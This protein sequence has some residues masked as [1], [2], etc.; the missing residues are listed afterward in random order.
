M[1]DV[2]P[3]PRPGLTLTQKILI[4]LAVGTI[5]GAWVSW[6]YPA[7]NAAVA[8][9]R[10]TWLK[11]MSTGAQIFLRMIKMIIGPL[12]FSTLVV[13]VAGG[14]HAKAVGRMGLRAII[15]FEVVTTVALFLGLAAVNLVKPGAGIN[16]PP[17]TESIAAKPQTW[18]QILVHLVPESFMRAMAENDVLQVVVFSLVFALALGQLGERGKTFLHWCETLAEIMFKFT[19]LVMKFAPFGVGAAIG[20]TI[21]RSGVGVL[22]NLIWLI[23]TVYVATAIFIVFVLLPI[24]WGFKVPIRK[25]WKVVKEPALIAFSTTSS[26]AALPRALEN[27]ERLGCPRRIVSFVLPLGYTFNLDGTTLFLSLASIFVAQA[28]GMDLTLGQQ[29]TMMLTLMLT[30]KGVAGVPRAATV[31]LAA[32]AAQFNLPMEGVM[33][34][35]GV[36][37]LMDMV[38]TMTNVIGNCLATVVIAKWEGDFTEASDEELNQADAMGEL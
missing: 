35:F 21:G 29:L 3:A 33:L 14:G 37:A 12:L 5:V 22:V 38:R 31:I 26:E 16:L 17:T 19:N 9:T 23:G 8:A 13:G 20:A 6:A 2:T 25:F 36:D 10:E 1:A 24:A 4:G 7:D 34:V 30:S 15:Y 27:M 28:G 18:D 32:T 11:V